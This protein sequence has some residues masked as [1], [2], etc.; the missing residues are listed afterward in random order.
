[1][2]YGE[3]TPTVQVITIIYPVRRIE[4]FMPLL[5]TTLSYC[6][7]DTMVSWSQQSDVW[8]GD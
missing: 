8:A 7:L 1:M 2:G 5:L 6:E 4:H 3:S